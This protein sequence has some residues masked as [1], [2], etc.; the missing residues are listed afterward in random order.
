MFNRGRGPGGAPDRV[1]LSGAGAGW[2]AG[3]AAETSFRGSG[4]VL[5]LGGYRST[6][7]PPRPFLGVLARFGGGSDWHADKVACQHRCQGRFFD[8]W[9][10]SRPW[11]ATHTPAQ[12]WRPSLR[13]LAR[14][15]PLSLFP[16]VGTCMQLMCAKYFPFFSPSV[17]L[18][19]PAGGEDLF[20]RPDLPMAGPPRATERKP[21]SQGPVCK[22]QPPLGA[23][24][25]LAEV[26]A[27]DG[28][29]GACAE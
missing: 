20:L 6:L 4:R 25:R 10:G 5:C 1:W 12:D 7:A 27:E 28:W 18:F 22:P 29:K 24:R 14:F 23:E 9:M 13:V 2:A 8:R 11:G 15:W 21:P 16:P 17:P 19:D 3:W 26:G